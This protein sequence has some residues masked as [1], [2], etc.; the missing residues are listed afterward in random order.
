MKQ[1]LHRCI[2]KYSNGRNNAG[3]YSE[4]AS[5]HAI[6][7]HWGLRRWYKFFCR[8]SE[9][10]LLFFNREGRITKCNPVAARELGYGREWRNVRIQ[11][12][13]KSTFLPGKHGPKVLNC[14]DWPEETVAYRKNHTC[15][16]V[17]LKVSVYK[18]GKYYIGQCRARK[19]TEFG[20]KGKRQGQTKNG[21]HPL[22]SSQNRII[23]NITHELRTPVNGILGLSNNLLD[24]PLTPKQQESVELIKRCCSNM[25]ITINNLLDYSRLVNDKM[26]LEQREFCFHDFINSVLDFNRPGINDK[27][28]KLLFSIS[29]DI[30][31]RVIGDEFRLT[32]ILNNLISNAVKF[33]AFGHVIL[34]V[35][36][37]SQT[38]Q[39]VELFFMVMD[40]GIGISMEEKDKLFQSFSQVDG[41]ITRRFGGTG[42]GLAISKGLVEAMGGFID[43]DSEKGKGSTFSFSVHLGLPD[44]QDEVY[45]REGRDAGEDRHYCGSPVGTAVGKEIIADAEYIDRSLKRAGNGRSEIPVIFT[46]QELFKSISAALEKLSICIDMERWDKAEEMVYLIRKKLPPE[47][48]DIAKMMFRLLLEVRKENYSASIAILGE[49]KNLMKEG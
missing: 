41:S 40:T 20:E 27:G 5:W 4:C 38:D 8:N 25:E 1:L 42:L 3:E 14:L 43:V 39:S 11:E 49:L 30:P 47:L 19:Q 7:Y 35:T 36:S 17:Q 44:R 34:K 24:T 21:F 32:Q 29:E 18:C 46:R 15:F 26:D 2:G 13:F 6:P 23:A 12:I 22:S 16:P 45:R 28:L 9:E 31:E 10:M 37:L 48:R 33:T